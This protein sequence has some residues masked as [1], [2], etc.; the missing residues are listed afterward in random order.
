MDWLLENLIQTKVCKLDQDHKKCKKEKEKLESE[1]YQLE[2][3]TN[4]RDC[5]G[6]PDACHNCESKGEAYKPVC[7]R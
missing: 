5:F 3:C 1:Q 4:V 2:E 7:A 6:S